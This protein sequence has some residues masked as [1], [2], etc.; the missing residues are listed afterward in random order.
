RRSGLPL[1]PPNARWTFLHPI[2]GKNVQ[3]VSSSSAPDRRGRQE[4]KR[5]LDAYDRRRRR[6][7]G[8]SGA[9]SR[10]SASISAESSGRHV[11]QKSSPK[12]V[13]WMLRRT[14][15]VRRTSFIASTTSG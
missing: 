1:Q 4:T 3:R 5:D 12:G 2:G 9:A 8:F 13:R 11:S 7:R 14:V 6:P 15:R 10:G